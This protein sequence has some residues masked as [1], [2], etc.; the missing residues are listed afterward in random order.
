MANIFLLV[1]AVLVRGSALWTAGEPRMGHPGIF[2]QTIYQWI[3]PYSTTGWVV[4]TLLVVIQGVMINVLVGRYRIASEVSLLPGLFYVLLSSFFSEFLYLSPLIMANTFFILALMEAFAT[5]RKY[6]AAGA[7]FNVGFWTAIGSL[8]YVSHSV[9]FIVA[10]IGLGMLRSFNFRERLMVVFGL[11]TPY[12]LTAVYFFI[13]NRL[14]VFYEVQFQNGLGIFEFPKATGLIDYVKIGLFGLLLGF[15]VLS[16][17]N[18]TKKKNIQ[19]QKYID[20]LFVCMAVT[21]LT[22]LYQ[23]G[24][25]MDHLLILVPPAAILL[26]FAFQ[27][28]RSRFAEAVHL[29][30]LVAMAGLVAVG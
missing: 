19:K 13:N 7:I 1:Y 9:V 27:D 29:L 3:P 23:G 11:L 24:I 4:A 16:Y 2:S 12:V 14:P 18:F 8:F 26:S 22:L 20:L 25:Q 15:L 21:V 10:M 17:G 30:M 28:A 6:Q 5:Y